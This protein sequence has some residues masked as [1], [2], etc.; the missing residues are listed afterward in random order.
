M[1]SS[2]L[3]GGG[4]E[5]KGA[6]RELDEVGEGPGDSERE[7]TRPLKS[8]ANRTRSAWWGGTA[9]RADCNRGKWEG[10]SQGEPRGGI[11]AARIQTIKPAGD[12]IENRVD[13]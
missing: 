10:W 9:S 6:N 3:R 5:S 1:G 12:E 2:P 4:G 8:P 13:Q 11:Y 7:P